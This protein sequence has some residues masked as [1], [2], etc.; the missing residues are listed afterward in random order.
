MDVQTGTTVSFAIDMM[1]QEQQIAY[2]VI[3][4]YGQAP[5]GAVTFSNTSFTFTNAPGN[6]CALTALTTTSAL[7]TFS[8]PVPSNGGRTCSIANI[9]IYAPYSTVPASKYRLGLPPIS[10][11]VNTL[12]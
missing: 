5:V 2:F 10:G 1:M 11:Q 8:T 6:G 7:D 4:G 12:R 9:T 3:E